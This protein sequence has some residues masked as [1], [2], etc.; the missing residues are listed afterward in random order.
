VIHESVSKGTQF[1]L[2]RIQVEKFFENHNQPEVK[3]VAWFIPHQGEPYKKIEKLA[4]YYENKQRR[5]K[6][7]R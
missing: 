5:R 3:N 6:K 7:N 1:D 2:L 4:K